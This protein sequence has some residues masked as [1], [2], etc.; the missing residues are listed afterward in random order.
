VFVV[1]N[2]Q[3]AIS[4]PRKAQTAAVTLAQKAIAVG[5]EGVQVDGNDVVAVR[6]V[7]GQALEKARS[8]G[9]ATL[10]EAL[11]YRLRDHTT[12]DDA[13]RYRD[14]EEVAH[15]WKEE[16]IAR[17]RAYLT[18]AHGWSRREEEELVEACGSEIAAAAE[19]YLTQG[20]E[21]P[22]AMFDHLHAHC[23]AALTA[24]RRSVEQK[25][26]S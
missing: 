19:A 15:H 11:T 17:L 7:V 9:G 10:V 25:A 8:G 5:F 13:S 6:E 18:S 4:V 16:P 22:A 2:N 23:P 14:D 24:Q 3:W 21:E 26:G 12:A 20:P 1:A